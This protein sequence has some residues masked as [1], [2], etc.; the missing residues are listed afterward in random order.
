MIVG[1]RLGALLGLV[2][3]LAACG[4]RT[5]VSSASEWTDN[6]NRA[7]VQLRH[8]AVVVEA[9]KDDALRDDSQLFVLLVA[10]TD[11]GGCRHMTDA[12]GTA[13]KSMR[14]VARLLEQACAGLERGAALFTRATTTDD[15]RALREARRIV[16]RSASTLVR[17]QIRLRLAAL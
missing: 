13:P 2:L 5:T 3:L 11:F 14:A 16:A 12:A 17:A 6:T 4:G 8:D 7:I 9:S 10:Y 1:M 15:V